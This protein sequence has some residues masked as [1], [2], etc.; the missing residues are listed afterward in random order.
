[1]VFIYVISTNLV[2]MFHEQTF[3]G[4]F[5]ANPLLSYIHF[6]LLLTFMILPVCKIPAVARTLCS[7]I[8]SMKIILYFSL[9]QLQGLFV[10]VLKV[11][12]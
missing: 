10:L 11:L 9:Q 4:K 3:E 7:D 5:G 12:K 2:D 1:M 8:K 6:S